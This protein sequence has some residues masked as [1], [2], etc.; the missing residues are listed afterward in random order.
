MRHRQEGLLCAHSQSNGGTSIV[1]QLCVL[2]CGMQCLGPPTGSSLALSPICTT[3]SPAQ[4]RARCREAMF[5]SQC[6]TPQ[7]LSSAVVLKKEG[8]IISSK[9]STKDYQAELSIHQLFT[10]G[11]SKTASERHMFTNLSQLTHLILFTT[12]QMSLT[13]RMAH[14]TPKKTCSAVA[15]LSLE[16]RHNRIFPATPIRPNEPWLCSALGTCR[17]RRYITSAG[18]GGRLAVPTIWWYSPGSPFL[19]VLW[20]LPRGLEVKGF[21]HRR[22]L[23]RESVV[24]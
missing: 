23:W 24:R 10:R 9:V 19:M 7:V 16:A 20:R 13:L 5:P 3:T 18:A 1:L 8:N 17:D 4:S 2:H 15:N 14:L 11:V 12:V 22:S 6:L 21:L